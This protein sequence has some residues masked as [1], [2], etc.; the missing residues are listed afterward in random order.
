MIDNLFIIAKVSFFIE[1]ISLDRYKSVFDHFN[2]RIWDIVFS[3][4]SLRKQISNKRVNNNKYI[5]LFLY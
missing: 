2:N 4:L 3:R 5:D 1:N